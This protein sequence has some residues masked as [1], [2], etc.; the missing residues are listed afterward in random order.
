MYRHV[1]LC[2]II[3]AW[4]NDALEMVANK[5]LEDVDMSEQMR[6]LCVSMCQHF[7]QSVRTLSDHYYAVL[8]RQNYVTP[9]SYLELIL[10]FKTLLSR[11]RTEIYNMRQRYVVGLEKLEFAA[12]QVSVMQQELQELQPQLVQTSKETDELMVKIEKDTVEAE[13]KKQV[14]CS[15]I[16]MIGSEPHYHRLWPL[17]RQWLMKLLASPKPSKMSVRQ[18]LQRLSL[19]WRQPSMP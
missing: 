11:R 17:M 8:R 15:L 1:T 14:R 16:G 2:V 10:T 6:G 7:H 19:H 9:T 13:A 5:F 3:Q 18:T 12:G 4:P